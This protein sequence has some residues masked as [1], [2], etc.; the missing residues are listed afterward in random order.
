M[1]FFVVMGWGFVFALI[2]FFLFLGTRLDWSWVSLKRSIDKETYKRRLLYFALG[3]I[4]VLGLAAIIYWLKGIRHVMGVSLLG[5]VMILVV[6]LIALALGIFV[7]MLG[8]VMQRA[9]ML[10]Y[11]IILQVAAVILLPVCA[12]LGG[13]L[14]LVFCAIPCFMKEKDQLPPA[15]ESS[16]IPA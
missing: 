16:S 6:L 1:T 9:K 15:E 8:T 14:Y 10:Q 13:W 4:A 5:P 7:V 3:M 12:I 11:G 2:F